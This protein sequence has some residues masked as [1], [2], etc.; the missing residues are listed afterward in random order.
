VREAGDEGRILVQRSADDLCQGGKHGFQREEDDCSN[1]NLPLLIS[2]VLL[3]ESLTNVA[4]VFA[5]YRYGLWPTVPD[6]EL[7]ASL[8]AA[9]GGALTLVLAKP[10][11]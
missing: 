4:L 1:L 3:G 6:M 7:A 2:A 9:L 5:T 8:G 11:P 10:F